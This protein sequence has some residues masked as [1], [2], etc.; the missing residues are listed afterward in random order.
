M[1]TSSAEQLTIRPLR[2]S[3]LDQ[4]IA[5]SDSLG[6]SPWS[7]EDLESEISREDS[8]SF[9]FCH[10]NAISGF[11]VSR[12]VPGSTAAQ[13]DAEIYNIGGFVRASNVRAIRLYAAAGFKEAARRPDFYTDPTEDAVVMSLELRSS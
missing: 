3:D 11:I 13:K 8:R 4:V 6:L 5:I 2:S 9:A 1:K 12:I 10:M 7:R